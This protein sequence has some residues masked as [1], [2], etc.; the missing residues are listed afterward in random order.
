[1]NLSALFS[2]TSTGALMLLAVL[3]MAVLL[4]ASAAAPA[5][6][7]RKSLR[8]AVGR[9]EI[10]SL[11][12]IMDWIEEHYEGQVVEVELENENG[13]FGYEVDL[14]T[15]SGSKIEFQF[16]ARSGELLSISG[17]DIEQAKRK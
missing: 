17:R 14:L 13:V 7:G 12:S 16:D 9:N 6:P 8:E 4:T 2:R 1:M 11:K 3:F 5:E 10:V 15:P